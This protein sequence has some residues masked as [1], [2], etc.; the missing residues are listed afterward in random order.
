[1]GARSVRVV[2]VEVP[3]DH[4]PIEAQNRL[5]SEFYFEL[6]LLYG[7]PNEEWGLRT[8]NVESPLYVYWEKTK[9]ICVLEVDLPEQA[10]WCVILKVNSLEGNYLAVHP[11]RYRMRVVEGR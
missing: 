10:D 4:F 7:D 5:A 1:M 3:I 6:V 9:R 2:R 8:E 11:M